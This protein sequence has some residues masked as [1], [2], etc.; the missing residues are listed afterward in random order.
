MLAACT[1]RVEPIK[2]GVMHSLTGTMAISE[3]SLRDAVLMAVDEINAKG[4]VLGR[5]IEPVVVD[6]RSNWDLFAEQ[7]RELLTERA[8]RS[9]LRVLDVGEQEVGVAGLRVAE[10]PALLSRSVPRARR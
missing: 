5:R 6:P 2:I 7:A 1:Q 8:S 4:G 3:T 10:W 9:G